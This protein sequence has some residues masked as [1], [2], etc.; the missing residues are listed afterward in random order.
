[1]KKTILTIAT[2]LGFLFA[3]NTATAAGQ[4]LTKSHQDWQSYRLCNGARCVWRAAVRDL[5]K[6]Q[7]FAVDFSDDGTFSMYILLGEVP[8]AEMD[9]WSGTTDIADG[10]VRV[11]RKRIRKVEILK[12]LNRDIRVITYSLPTETLDINF[13][14]ELYGGNTLRFRIKENGSYNISSFSLRGATAAI[15]RALNATLKIDDDRAYFENED[16]T[17]FES[18]KK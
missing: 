2:A 9:T 7:I 6:P 1:M 12:V 10:E 5:E 16:S 14:K 3:A 13:I 18:S 15:S 8:N 4:A 11:D 17:Y